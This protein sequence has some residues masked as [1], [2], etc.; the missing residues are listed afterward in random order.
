MDLP[1][2]RAAQSR[3]R[4]ADS[5]NLAPPDAEVKFVLRRQFQMLMNEV[6]RGGQEHSSRYGDTVEWYVKVCKGDSSRGS[7]HFPDPLIRR[8]FRGPETC[9][10]AAHLPIGM[11]MDLVPHAPEFLQNKGHHGS[12]TIGSTCPQPVNSRVFRATTCLRR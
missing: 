5:V 10:L 2:A 7:D 9:P 1:S 11:H 8:Q 6:R 4:R 3:Q 12:R